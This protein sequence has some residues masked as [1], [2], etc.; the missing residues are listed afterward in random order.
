MI[1]DSAMSPHCALGLFLICVVFYVGLRPL[2]DRNYG[3]VASGFRWLFWLIPLWLL[4]MLP[5]ADWL[6]EQRWRRVL[7]LLL[8]ARFDAVGA[9]PAAN[10]WTHPWIY[11]CLLSWQIR[12]VA[13]QFMDNPYQSP[14]QDD[15]PRGGTVTSGS[16]T[17]GVLRALVCG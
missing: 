16:R 10:P 7:A 15:A 12:R 11:Q 1:T 2:G 14:A 17:T 13:K 8:L 4:V 6:S 9:L 5:T 3:G